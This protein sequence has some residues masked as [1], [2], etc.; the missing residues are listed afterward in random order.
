MTF[1]LPLCLNRKLLF[2]KETKKCNA[3]KKYCSNKNIMNHKIK[4]YSKPVKSI[5]VDSSEFL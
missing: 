3:C 4:L 1:I 5:I 2:R